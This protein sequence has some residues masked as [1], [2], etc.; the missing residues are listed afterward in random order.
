MLD[1]ELD[2]ETQQELMASFDDLY[3]ETEEALIN[4]AK[5]ADADTLAAMFRA[6][7]SIKGNAGMFQFMEIV[8]YTHAMENVV[9]L[10]R[11]GELTLTEKVCEALQVGMDRLRDLHHRDVLGLDLN[12]IGEKRLKEQ[13]EAMV[14]GGAEAI[15]RIALEVLGLHI[16]VDEVDV[17]EQLALSA[18]QAFEKGDAVQNDL[19]FFQELALQV[20]N[21]SQYWLGRSIQ[22]FDWALKINQ[23]GGG[24][25]P[26]EQ[27]AAAAYMHDI[28]MSFIPIELLRKDG[29]FDER[30][31]EQVRMHAAWGHGILMRMRGW[32]E[33][34]TITLQHHEFE[35]GKGYPAQLKGEQIH[36]GAHILAIVDAFFSM[37]NGRADRSSRRSALRAISEINAQKGAQFSEFWVDQFN[38][39]IK[40]E[41]RDGMI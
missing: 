11:E 16:E 20:D 7:H 4:L 22:V 32:E 37:T 26:Y 10:A 33:A 40:K 36:P 2:Q 15:D 19:L 21:Q 17:S 38:L 35:N 29:K 27:M 6:I 18:R 1:N 39:M 9:G 30:E 24:P 8:D 5:V 13:F 28:G 3:N 34:A 31:R 25:V 12:A 14:T 41:I 23:I